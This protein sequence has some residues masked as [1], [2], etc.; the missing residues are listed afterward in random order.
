MLRF[1]LHNAIFAVSHVNGKDMKTNK[2][3]YAEFTQM[4]TE[5]TDWKRLDFVGLCIKNGWDALDLEKTLIEEMGM[6]GQEIIETCR[7]K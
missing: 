7:K 3:D 1:S 4:I 6:S 2:N 5:G